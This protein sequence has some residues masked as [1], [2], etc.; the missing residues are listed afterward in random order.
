MANYR[1][2]LSARHADSVSGSALS[3]WTEP[4]NCGDGK[5]ESVE[6]PAWRRLEVTGLSTQHLKK[7]NG[8]KERR[9][10]FTASERL[11]L[12]QRRQQVF[13]AHHP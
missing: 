13:N 4:G 1:R 11:P 5:P 2:A 6:F 12:E 7:H 10:H 8:N 3:L 9:L